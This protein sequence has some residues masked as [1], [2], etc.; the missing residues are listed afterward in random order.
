MGYSTSSRD[1]DRERD[2]YSNRPINY[3]FH[4]QIPYTHI[5]K[6][7]THPPPAVFSKSY[8]PYCNATKKLLTDLK[9]NFYSI[10]LDQVG[11]WHS[12]VPSL[13]RL[14]HRHT[15]SPQTTDPQS[16]PTSPR[17]R[18][19]PLSPTSSS[20]RN[21]WVETRICRRRIRRI[22]RVS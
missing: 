1:K 8:C 20:V 16:N 14:K 17:R 2:E 4:T 13:P 22:W 10:E 15:N 21:T 12:I 6:W 7:L 19:K 11:M 9:A 5:H 3:S 18:V